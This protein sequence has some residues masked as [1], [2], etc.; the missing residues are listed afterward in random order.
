MC[1]RRREWVPF[2]GATAAAVVAWLA[3][4]A[5]AFL[6]GRED[7]QVFWTFNS[8]RGAALGSLWLVLAQNGHD[9]GHETINKASWIFFIAWCIGVLLLGLAAPKTQRLAQLGFLIVAGFLLVHTVYSKN[10]R[11]HVRTPVTNA[12]RVCRLLLEKK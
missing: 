8:E 1:I 7:W 12:Q 9:F 2:V 10:G 4:N 11:A 3:A 6:T 5:P